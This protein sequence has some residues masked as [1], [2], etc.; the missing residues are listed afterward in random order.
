MKI[1]KDWNAAKQAG[2]V[3]YR[4]SGARDNKQFCMLQ[5]SP[6][7]IFITAMV[8]F[9]WFYRWFH[10]GLM[11]VSMVFNNGLKCVCSVFESCIL[12]VPGML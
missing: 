10:C 2:K 12:A 1:K 4:L 9:L 8:L 5:E 6:A 3:L 11:G 7:I